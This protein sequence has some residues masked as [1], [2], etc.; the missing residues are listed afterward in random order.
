MKNF[1]RIF[2]WKQLINVVFALQIFFVVNVNAAQNAYLQLEIGAG[3]P[4]A[5][6]NIAVVKEKTDINFKVWITDTVTK[7][8][9]M[10]LNVKQCIYKFTSP[11]GLIDKTAPV[12]NAISS[13][14]HSAELNVANFI[15]DVKVTASRLTKGKLAVT[16]EA[17][18]IFNDNSSLTKSY[19]IN[20]DVVEATVTVYAKKPDMVIERQDNNG[21]KVSLYICNDNSGNPYPDSIGHSF[22]QC[23][24]D[25][26]NSTYTSEQKNLSGKKFGLY[27]KNNQLKIF[28][29]FSDVAGQILSDD[30]HLYSAGRTYH[31]TVDKAKKLIDKT[32]SQKKLATLKYNLI[33]QSADNCTS[34]CVKMCNDAGGVSP[35]GKGLIG[36]LR[37]ENVT[38]CRSISDQPIPNPYHHAVQIEA[39]R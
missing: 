13:D 24:I 16:L 36:I 35:D 10:P 29:L 17:K 23:S 6:P 28:N 25:E 9:V 14:K 3:K 5:S 19:T 38:G 30:S 39:I 18:V 2:D 7:K 20:I 12:T 31:I 32:I 22:W 33:A 21:N 34:L 1:L 26:T 27:P 37:D 4:I 11:E 8:E 15:A